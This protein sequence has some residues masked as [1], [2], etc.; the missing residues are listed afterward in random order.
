MLK[1]IEIVPGSAQVITGE[2]ADEAVHDLVARK[3]WDEL[4][5]QYPSLLRVSDPVA[6]EQ[7]ILN[8]MLTDHEWGVELIIKYLDKMTTLSHVDVVDRIIA[9]YPEKSWRIA[10]SLKKFSGIDHTRLFNYFLDEDNISAFQEG[11]ENFDVDPS[12]YVEIWN[13]CIAKERGFYITSMKAR[14]MNAGKIPR[15]DI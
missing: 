15:E 12:R 4:F 8:G 14:L 10:Q 1:N 2:K 3:R 7:N 13:L 5:Q 6:I 9:A 11:I